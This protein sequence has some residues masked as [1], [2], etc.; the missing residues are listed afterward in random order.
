MAST[1]DA[2]VRVRVNARVSEK[3]LTRRAIERIL[4]RTKRVKR[5]FNP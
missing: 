4:G 2:R 3:L 5:D 1:F